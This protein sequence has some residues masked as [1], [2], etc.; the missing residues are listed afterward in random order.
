MVNKHSRPDAMKASRILVVR[1]GHTL[2]LG[3]TIDGNS[4]ALFKA[5]R[6]E[7]RHAAKREGRYGC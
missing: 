1:N 5:V 2:M 7:R 4:A 6:Q 3:K